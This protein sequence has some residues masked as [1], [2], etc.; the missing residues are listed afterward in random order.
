MFKKARPFLLICETPLH[1]GSGNDL[2]IVDLPIQRERHTKFPKIEASSLKGSIREAFEQQ[3]EIKKKVEVNG[4]EEDR[5]YWANTEN[6]EKLKDLFGAEPGKEV[7]PSAVSLAFGPD[8]GDLYAGALGFTDARI[9]LFPVKSMKGVF[10]WITCRSILE[11]FINDLELAGFNEK[12][13]ELPEKGTMPNDSNL[14]IK[15]NK[16]I[17]EE[18]TINELSSNEV[19]THFAVW[20]A[21][22]IFPEASPDNN[23]YWREKMEKD[24]LVL[25]DDDFNDFITLSTEIIT[26]TKINSETG[27]VQPGALFTEEYLPADSVLYSLALASPIFNKEKGIFKKNNKTE[28]ELVI[29]F[30]EKGLPEVIQLGANATLGKGIT[31]MRLI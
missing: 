20:L 27:T 19:C 21:K 26:R 14:K 18:Y 16:V 29:E 5:Y 12:I 30:F 10:G 31:R 17:L 28:E 9:L 4:K 8:E 3:V 6:I 2:G 7:N 22:K 13:P 25:K 11:R 15:D 1:A 23:K 24:I